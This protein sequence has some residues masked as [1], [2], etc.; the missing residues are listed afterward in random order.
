MT[1][2]Q[3]MK[4]AML[5]LKALHSIRKEFPT[6]KDWQNA[7]G[8]EIGYLDALIDKSTAAL[9]ELLTV[10]NSQICWI[11]KTC[12]DELLAGRSVA[13]TLTCHRAFSE[14]VPL[15]MTPKKR[16]WVNLTYFDER[17]LVETHKRK[18][19]LIR[20]AQDMLRGQNG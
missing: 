10:P 6:F 1:E 14:D 13:T 9:K 11:D 4:Q 2:I 16:P 3:P 19:T 17:E 20:A 15:Y 18:L 8:E 7:D 5:A 12:I